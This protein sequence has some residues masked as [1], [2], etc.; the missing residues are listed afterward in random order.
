MVKWWEAGERRLT[1]K[2]HLEPKWIRRREHAMCMPK[3][4]EEMEKKRCVYACILLR[5]RKV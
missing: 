5:V 4:G 2:A 1:I 3:E